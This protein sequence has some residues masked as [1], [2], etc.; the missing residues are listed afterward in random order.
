MY[1]ADD[2]PFGD[3]YDWEHAGCHGVAV[4]FTG[5]DDAN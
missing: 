2:Q 5:T 1:G 3:A 4:H